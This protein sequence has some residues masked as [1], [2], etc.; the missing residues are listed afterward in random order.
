MRVNGGPRIVK[1]QTLGRL[2]A[3]RYGDLFVR[4]C[5][6]EMPQHK[7]QLLIHLLAVRLLKIRQIA[8][9]DYAGAAIDYGGQH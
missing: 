8:C 6:D 9:N 7:F 3:C 4:T 2:L 5:R 1:Q